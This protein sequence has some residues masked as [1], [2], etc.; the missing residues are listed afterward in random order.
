M[1]ELEREKR[2]KQMDRRT[3]NAYP[4]HGRVVLGTTT[5]TSVYFCRPTCIRNPFCRRTYIYLVNFGH[6]HFA[7]R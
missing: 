4:D 2:V 6:M 3:S 5:P 7:R 1:N